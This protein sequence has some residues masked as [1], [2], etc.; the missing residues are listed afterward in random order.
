LT[1]NGNYLDLKRGKQ[2]LALLTVCLVELVEA[3]SD[4]KE[5]EEGYLPVATFV[6]VLERR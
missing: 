3:E 6:L 5:E 4:Q 2:A 1:S